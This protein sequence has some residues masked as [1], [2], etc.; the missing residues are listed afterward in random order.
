M[1]GEWNRATFQYDPVGQAH[2]FDFILDKLESALTQSGWVRPSWDT[3][4][5]L[6]VLSNGNATESRYFIRADRNTQVRWRYTGDVVLQH[7]GIVVSYTANATGV[8][9]ETGPQIVIQSFLQ[10][11]GATGVMVSTQDLIGGSAPNFRFGSIRVSID[12]LTVNNYLVYVGEDGLYLESGSDGL[13]VNLG[14]AAVMTF[15]SIPELHGTRDEAVQWTAQGLI[16]DLTRNCK[17][18]A[19][20][21]DRFVTNDGTNK[22]FTASLQ[23][24]V[25]RGTIDIDT[26]AAN[27]A[28]HRFHY[29]GSRDTFLSVGTGVDPGN[30]TQLSASRSSS[31]KFSATFG[32]FS[33]PKNNRFRISQLLMLQDLHHFRGAVNSAVASD[34][35]AA[36]A[37]EQ[38]FLDVRTYRQIH[39][40]AAVD[41]TLLPFVNVTDAVTGGV[42]RVARIADNGRFSQ[43]GIEVPS[44][45]LTLP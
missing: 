5:L 6:Q 26:L 24:Q 17:F 3:G 2:T 13:A 39:R 7:G 15:G 14:H 32:L 34:N 27:V 43:I 36:S 20:R 37:T 38:T 4:S 1:P 19:Q 16:C 42:Y 22:N 44:V 18:T 41:Y 12:N 29:I 35:V 31:A 40:F 9:A 25:P 23:P 11:A 30:T 8:G 10:N 45:T 33:S 21:N 28:N